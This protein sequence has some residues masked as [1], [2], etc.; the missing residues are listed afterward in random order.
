MRRISV[1]FL[2]LIILAACSGDNSQ[3]YHHDYVKCTFYY[4]EG[5]LKITYDN[6][7]GGVETTHGFVNKHIFPWEFKTSDGEFVMIQKEPEAWSCVE[8]GNGR[9]AIP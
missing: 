5:A 2:F 7:V 9:T 1:A 8:D 4:E 6:I 3:Q